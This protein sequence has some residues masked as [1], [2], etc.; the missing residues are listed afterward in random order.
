MN[1]AT[2]VNPPSMAPTMGA[3]TPN[4]APALSNID[5]FDQSTFQ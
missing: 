3:M 2:L 1:G 5:I 4:M